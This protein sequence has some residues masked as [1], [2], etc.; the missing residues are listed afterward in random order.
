[1]NWK[2]KAIVG[3]MGHLW[4]H[5]LNPNQVPDSGSMNGRFADCTPDGQGWKA[6]TCPQ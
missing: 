6:Y 2:W 5:K 3:W 1:V 4:N